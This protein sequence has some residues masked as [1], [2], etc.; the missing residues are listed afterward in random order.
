[1]YQKWVPGLWATGRLKKVRVSPASRNENFCMSSACWPVDMARRSRTRIAFRLTLGSAGASSGKNLRTGSSIESLPSE[2]ARPTAVEVKLLLSENITWGSSLAKGDH[3]PSAT[4][5]PWRTTITLWTASIF[6]SSASTK[7][8]SCVEESP[9][10]PVS[11]RGRG[12]TRASRGVARRAHSRSAAAAA[13]DRVL[14]AA[15]SLTPGGLGGHQAAAV[16]ADDPLAHALDHL[17]IVGGHEHGGP[18][19]IDLLEESHDLLGH[20]RVEV[21]GGSS[22]R[23]RIGSLMRARAIATRCCSPPESWSGIGVHLVVEAHR[24]EGGEGPPLLLLGGIPRIRSTKAT[25]SRMVLRFRSLKSWNTTP[26]ERR[27]SG[28]WRAGIAVMLR[29]PPGS[30]PGSEAPRGRPA[31]GR[32]SCPHPRVR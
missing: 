27:S 11:F 5:W 15:D 3:Q 31:S 13:R 21:P 1:L 8:R 22:A 32:W 26:I 6:D 29:P 10:P 18:P 20:V 14:M 30:A 17:A 16:E 23:S 2:T 24:L 7:A 4:T 19:R 25:F 9:P 28:I 12:V